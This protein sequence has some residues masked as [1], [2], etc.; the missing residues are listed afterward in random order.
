MF[1][2]MKKIVFTLAAIATL[3]TSCVKSEGEQILVEKN[4]TIAVEVAPESRTYT[5]GTNIYWAETGEQL[6]IIYFADESTSRRQSPTHTDYT[7]VDN[8]AQFTADFTTTD[9]ATKYTFGAFQVFF[10]AYAVNF[11]TSAILRKPSAYNIDGC[12][13]TRTVN[14]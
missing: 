9:G 12:R 13:F 8:R 10:K 2:A 11:N 6:N 7:L 1:E 5:D 3:F 14:A 4:T